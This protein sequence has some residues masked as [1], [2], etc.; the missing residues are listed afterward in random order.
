VLAL[1]RE[2]RRGDSRI[3]PDAV[4]VG[5]VRAP[6]SGFVAVIAGG[7]G[8]VIVA[9]LNGAAPSCAPAAVAEALELAGGGD[10][11]VD[12]RRLAAAMA[13]I[14][15]W[16]S[17]RDA[18]K[19]SGLDVHAVARARRRVLARITRVVS[20]A[21]RHLRS[22]V[23]PL[24]VNARRAVLMPLGAGAERIL[25]ELADA[26][27][28]DQAW[29]RAVGAFGEAHGRP[30]RQP[31]SDGALDRG[32]SALLLLAAMADEGLP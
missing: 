21:P 7:D 14:D 15:T 8:P 26:P 1:M 18:A 30:A 11:P 28:A 25:G 3:H 17:R 12:Q 29:L 6:T 31:Q 16:I 19:L 13:D 20:R 23:T 27:L 32:L 5:A 22:V 10:V 2:W 4:I 24:A 9:S